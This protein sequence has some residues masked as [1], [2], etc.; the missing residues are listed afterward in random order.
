MFYKSKTYFYETS[1]YKNILVLPY[2]I[3]L[4]KIQLILRLLKVHLVFSF[5][6][7]LRIIQLKILPKPKI[8]VFIKYHTIV[9]DHFILAKRITN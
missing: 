9:V 7:L 2:N 8:L 1:V 4:A 6:I 3:K 5:K